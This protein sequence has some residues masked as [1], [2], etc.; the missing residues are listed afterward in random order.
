MSL[1]QTRCGHMMDLCAPR[2]AD[3]D[4]REI[5]RSLADVNRHAGASEP[6]V[7]VALHTLIALDVA[8]R[9]N[10][11]AALPYVALRRAPDAWF[12]DGT[13]PWTRALGAE[14]AHRLGADVADDV[15]LVLRDLHDRAFEAI[16]AAAGL[17]RPSR[18]I[19]EQV[20]LVGRIAL[21]TE[22]R[23]FMA[24]PSRPWKA[25]L[26]ALAD[27]PA[28]RRKPRWLAPDRAADALVER[29]RQLLPALR[30]EPA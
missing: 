13:A 14:L 30:A 26:E 29:L 4:L 22:R 1:S 11:L 5:A 28:T 16:L 7:S 6:A 9:L 17:A 25:S 20:E 10:F 18:E 2:A 15:S 23:W 21:M 3:V 24:P 12:G 8:E 27:H 19:V